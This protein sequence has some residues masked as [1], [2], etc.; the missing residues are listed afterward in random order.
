MTGPTASNIDLAQ[1][2]T[3]LT[4]FRR[5]SFSAAAEDLGVTQS[6]VSY[7]VNRLR[8][9]FSDPLFVRQGGGIAP[10]DRCREIVSAASRMLDEMDSLARPAAF[11]PAETT[12]RVT[13]SCNA[14]ERMILIP[15]LVRRMRQD[16]PG[17]SLTI[18]TA[19]TH[20]NRHLLD[21]EADLVI[22]PVTM[23]D[24][25]IYGERLMTDHYVCV[26][27]PANPLVGRP[28][29]RATYLQARH[30]VVNYGGAWRSSYM[31][32]LDQA[33]DRLNATVD[34]PSPAE[35]PG[36]LTGTDLI[37]T[38]ASRLAGAFG[39][40]VHVSDCPVP[41]PFDIHLYWAARAHRS[42]LSAW[43]RRALRDIAAGL[44]DSV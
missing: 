38:V 39:D 12:G 13:I 11:D 16:T 34:T 25:G 30:A 28:L 33:G 18:L 32:D 5:N 19:R 42:A 24:S 29:D 43:L 36:L 27:D 3:L 31:L 20:G 7:A 14:Y 40:R 9:A 35:L 44:D 41:A 21:A 1:L 26:M 37:A 6:S 22:S 15:P 23:T 4:V 8:A 2:R 17:L 10:T